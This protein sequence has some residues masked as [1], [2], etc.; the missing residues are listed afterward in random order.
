MRNHALLPGQKYI[1]DSGWVG[2]FLLFLVLR[3]LVVGLTMSVC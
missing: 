2:F 3:M 1:W